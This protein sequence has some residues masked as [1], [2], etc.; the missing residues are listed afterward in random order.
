MT[1]SPATVKAKAIIQVGIVVRDIQA[2]MES[3]WSIFGI[4]PWSVIT[5]GTPSVQ[6]LKYF[7][8]HNW[9]RCNVAFS[10]V[11]PLEIELF[12][13]V[14][15]VSPYQDWLDNVGEG[16]HH[17]KFVGEDLNIERIERLMLE[18]GFPSFFSGGSRIAQFCYFDIMPTH[19]IWETSTRLGGPVANSVQY[20]ADPKAI[21][22]TKVKVQSIDQ[23]GI[24]VKDIQKTIEA[25]WNI[26]SIG[27]WEINDYE[28]PA[29]YDRT[30]C[31]KPAWARERTARAL[32]GDV[33]LELIQVI[34]GESIHSDYLNAHGE[35]LHHLRFAVDDLRKA[36]KTLTEQ[37]FVSL[38]SG[39]YG[40]TQEMTGFDYMY[41]NPLHCIWEIYQHRKGEEHDKCP[42]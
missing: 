32:I 31:G 2:T 12:E 36:T 15:G 23:V 16:L 6:N 42:G 17:L 11:G 4:G 1:T 20:P 28:Y 40:S 18:Q 38:Q 7:G 8:K 22:Q 14:E 33:E 25:Y 3:F 19:C 13:P 24:V 30:Y 35:G 5:F 34:D 37:G 29:I 27:P 10:Q 26:F 39:K 21:S 9:C 41:I